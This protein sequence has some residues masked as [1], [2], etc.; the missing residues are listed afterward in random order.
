MA[1]SVFCTVAG[2]EM[3]ILITAIEKGTKIP[4]RSMDTARQRMKEIQNDE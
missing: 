4:K 3:V 1:R 2:E